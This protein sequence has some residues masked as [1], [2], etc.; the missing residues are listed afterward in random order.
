MS[1][2]QRG[3]SGGIS[4]A[5]RRL[6]RGLG[7]TQAQLAQKLLVKPNSVSRYETGTVKPSPQIL[8]ILTLIAQGRGEHQLFVEEM[9]SAG[10]DSISRAGAGMQEVRTQ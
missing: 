1:Q 9:S 10:F 4:R 3:N 8:L 6:R 7:L 5:I 2:P